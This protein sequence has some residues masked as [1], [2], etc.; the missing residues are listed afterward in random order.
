[1]SRNTKFVP[2]KRSVVVTENRAPVSEKILC[3]PKLDTPHRECREGFD[4]DCELEAVLI[5]IEDEGL[6]ITDKDLS[7]ALEAFANLSFLTNCL[8]DRGA[9]NSRRFGGLG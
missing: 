2:G 5:P 8:I 9:E 1:M 6:D 7:E 4:G 3:I